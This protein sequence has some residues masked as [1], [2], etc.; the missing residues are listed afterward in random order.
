MRKVRI[1]QFL[2]VMSLAPLRATMA[3]G[4]Y[5]LAMLTTQKMALHGHERLTLQR[6]RRRHFV[7]A[8]EPAK[9]DPQPRLAMPTS[10]IAIISAMLQPRQL[11]SHHAPATQSIRQTLRGKAQWRARDSRQRDSLA[12]LIGLS[13]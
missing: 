5:P 4:P 6:Y 3:L 9:Y 12:H 13:P 7:S 1:D 10:A 8:N 2:A 11:N